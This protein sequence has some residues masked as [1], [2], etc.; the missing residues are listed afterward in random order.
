MQIYSGA[1]FYAVNVVAAVLLYQ[2]LSIRLIAA[3]FGL[4][5]IF[6]NIIN[7]LKCLN[8]ADLEQRKTFTILTLEA[9]L[10][11]AV[12]CV[13]FVYP[14]S[15]L[16]LC[17]IL[18]LVRTVTLN[19]FLRLGTSSEVSA[20]ALLAFR[21]DP[22]ADLRKL[23]LSNWRWIVIGGVSTVNW[24]IASTI[25]SK[26][27]GLAETATYEISYRLFSIAQ[28]LP[29]IV[30]TAVFPVLIRM[31]KAGDFEGFRVFYKH[32]YLYYLLFGLA[33]YCCIY[34][35]SD[36]LI[37][38]AFG[39]RYGS[40]AAASRGLFLTI[41]VFPT[42]LL[43][44][45]VLLAMK[46]EVL[47]MWFNVALLVVNVGVSLVGLHY[48]HSLLVVNIGLFASFAAFHVLQ[49]AVLIRRRVASLRHVITLHAVTVAVLLSYFL[50]AKVVGGMFV[51]PL[52]WFGVLL[53]L[54]SMNRNDP[55]LRPF[56]VKAGELIRS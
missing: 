39:A 14:F 52:Y 7:A 23:V 42:A 26:R 4:N 30:S 2:D 22:F 13:L 21:H 6:D 19:L 46:L 41:I 1:V 20:R 38:L 54:V 31:Y 40:A 24:R 27:L 50:L 10:K 47:D 33:A 16:T 49:D 25:V 15:I 55:V 3:V 17:A 32:V 9:F 8:V 45:N 56:F 37:P 12:G 36:V 34:S 48:V 35:Y 29:I 44:A 5:I 51:F 18:L 43:Q 53:V 11:A 28:M